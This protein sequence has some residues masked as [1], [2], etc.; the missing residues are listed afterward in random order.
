MRDYNIDWE[1]FEY[2]FFEKGPDWFWAL[3]II[4]I[5]IA[6][7]AIILNNILF[8]ILILIG[9]L[10][11]GIYAVRKPELVHYEVNQRGIVIDDRLYPYGSLDSFWV[12]HGV[13]KPKLLVVSKK[14]LM[15][16]IIIPLSPEVDTDLLR[17]YLLDHV[18]EEERREPISSRIMEY[19]GF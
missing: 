15:P 19:L 5:S 16:H 2:E 1:E 7:T 12:E 13:K 6:V 18:D 17:D 10:T 4:S 11:L 3:G 9:S 14:I 8:A